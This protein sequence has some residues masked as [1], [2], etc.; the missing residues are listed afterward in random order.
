MIDSDEGLKDRDEVLEE[1][2]SLF[3][4]FVEEVVALA[5]ELLD[6]STQNE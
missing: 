5:K 1:M 6:I 3:R 4:Y 2:R